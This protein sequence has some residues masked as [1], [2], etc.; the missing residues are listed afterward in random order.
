MLFDKF[1]LYLS[2]GFFGDGKG[3]GKERDGIEGGEE[4][5]EDKGKGG[6]ECVANTE[7]CTRKRREKEGK[8]E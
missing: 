3:D 7:E 6:L 2:G 1:P 8:G 4:V 5:R